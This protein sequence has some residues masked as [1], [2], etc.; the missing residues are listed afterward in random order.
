VA[1]WVADEVAAR[2]RAFPL[3]AAPR[4]VVLLDERVRIE[5]VFVDGDSKLA[6]MDGAVV[7]DPLL[8]PDLLAS[9]P[10]ARTHTGKTV[11]RVTDV[12][13][14]VAA[15]RC[16]H[17]PRLLP[18][19]RL[20]VTGL[21]GSCVILSPEVECWWSVLPSDLRRGQRRDATRRDDQ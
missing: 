17:G 4:P 18:A 9:L 20:Q 7:S 3:D 15:F 8:P 14:T 5:G 12:A 19:Y 11:L 1:D 2:W 21:R 6:W 16:D 13:S 10:A